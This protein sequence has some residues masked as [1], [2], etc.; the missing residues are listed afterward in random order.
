LIK[1]LCKIFLRIIQTHRHSLHLLPIK[2]LKQDHRHYMVIIGMVL[3]AIAKNNQWQAA[4]HPYAARAPP[5]G[6]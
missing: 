4:L 3:T 1:L 2:Y 5:V 6:L